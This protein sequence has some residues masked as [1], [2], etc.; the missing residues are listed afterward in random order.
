M[1]LRTVAA[2]T[3][4]IAFWLPLLF[5]LG[6]AI[7]RLWWEL[8]FYYREKWDFKKDS[9]NP[10]IGQDR[11]IARFHFLPLGVIKI[12][13]LI[14]LMGAFYLTSS[15]LIEGSIYRYNHFGRQGVFS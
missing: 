10:T 3:F 11:L 5:F 13:T 2:A 9:G 4:I 6:R 8:L 1:T 15:A 7:P 14:N 12:F